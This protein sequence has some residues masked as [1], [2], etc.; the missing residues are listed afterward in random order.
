M[1]PENLCLIT[2]P[3]FFFNKLWVEFVEVNRKNIFMTVLVVKE[4]ASIFP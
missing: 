3:R 4:L 2:E 1:K